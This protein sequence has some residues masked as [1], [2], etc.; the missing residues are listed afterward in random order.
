MNNNTKTSYFS[1]QEYVES[2]NLESLRD[3]ISNYLLYW[4][5][6][7]LSIS[8][9]LGVAYLY[10]KSIDPVYIV[11]AEFS[12]NDEK[13]DQKTDE[14]NYFF[15]DSKNVNDEIEILKSRTLMKNIVYN[16]Q[17]WT[18]YIKKGELKSSDIYSTT[19]VRFNL[20]KK[21]D[22]FWGH[23]I[24]ILIKNENDF[25]IKQ[26]HS[27]STFSY[28]DLLNSSFGNWKLEV[29]PYLKNFI[30][31]TIRINLYNP[32]T[33]IDNCLDSFNA[34]QL[35]EQTS[36]VKLILHEHV[37]ER[38]EDII[39]GIIKA[40]NQASIDY[41]NKVTASTL[42]FL[43]ERLVDISGE[44]NAVEKNVEGYKSSRG[45]TDISS[46]SKFYLD[47][48][49]DNDSHLNEV[50]VQLQV[51]DQIQR[52][53]T[54]PKSSGGA[55]ATIG[56]SDPGLIS[57]IDQLNKLELQRDKLLSNTPEK[58][59]I[60]APINRQ[61]KSTKAAIYENIKG[62]K[63]TFIAT[64]NQLNKYGSRFESSIKKL[65][66]QEREYIS[67]KRQQN[68]KEDLYI[69]LLQKREEIALNSASKLVRS[70]VIDPAHYGAPESINS[71]F[72]YAL[73]FILGIIIPGGSIFAKESLN[74]KINKVQQ[75]E[76]A[77]FVPVLCEL[78]YQKYMTPNKI[79]NS[80]GTMIS[81][82]FRILR[83][84]LQSVNSNNNS[85]RGKVTL[86]TSGMSGEGKSTITSNLGIVMSAAGRKT[87]I[88]DVDFRKSVI[89]KSFNL[90]N[91]SGLCDYLNGKEFKENIVKPSLIHPDLFIISSGG[92]PDNPSE[93]LEKNEMEELID[94]L[95]IHFDEVILDTPPIK[96]VA[97]A[98]IL[99]KFSDVNLYVIR[100]GFTYKSELKYLN[101]LHKEQKLKNL[102]VIFNGVS[103][104][105]RYGYSKDYACQYYTPDKAGFWSF[106]KKKPNIL[107]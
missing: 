85:R 5:F 103:S 83:T 57:L 94:W 66:G 27:T 80:P 105:N 6:F 44:L 71:S 54:S 97:D 33:V 87:I 88:V 30:G 59:P 15:K 12:I 101:Q 104:S 50:N 8:I 64:R 61:I 86:L 74:N 70:R 35:T 32:E 45:I 21:S 14:K 56:I 9:C 38:G 84:N 106:L 65:P 73:A 17:L 28:G 16:L 102:N 36:V 20:I 1:N 41:K 48:V 7:L 96:L 91:E 92:R 95:R 107:F 67:I 90:K 13:N 10:L 62:I 82:Q 46:N 68:I 43:D 26:P 3:K 99:A 69:Y 63:R 2:D 19:P 79:L 49:K 78:S 25:I 22:D 81:E 42:N 29:T 11:E 34:F 53:V 4:P 23:S 37:P 72:A 89:A 77:V 31:Q 75:I 40:Y 39:N 93:L 55:P 51:I 47:N 60:F 100:Y 58:N 98:M 24:E 18:Q 52:Y 76:D